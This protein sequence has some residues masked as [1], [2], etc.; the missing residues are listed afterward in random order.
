MCALTVPASC[1]GFVAASLALC[2]RLILLG[3]I[4]SADGKMTR[5]NVVSTH[6]CDH[7]K[8]S[9]EKSFVSVS[10]FSLC[11]WVKLVPNKQWPPCSQSHVWPTGAGGEAPKHGSSGLVH[12]ACV[13]SLLISNTKAARSTFQLVWGSLSLA[14]GRGFG[15]KRWAEARRAASLPA[16]QSIYTHHCWNTKITWQLF[17]LWH[18]RTSEKAMRKAQNSAMCLKKSRSQTQDVDHE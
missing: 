17:N 16:L 9:Y 8:A 18:L 14:K 11:V 2:D 5:W 12:H 7:L 13:E 1:W 10:L 6:T 3:I 15:V 4:H